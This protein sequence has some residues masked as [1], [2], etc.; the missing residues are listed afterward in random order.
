MITK[1]Q[2]DQADLI[3][4]LRKEAD[5]ARACFRTMATQALVFAPAGVAAIFV[6]MRF[7]PAAALA[8]LGIMI[9]VMAIQRVAIHK[10]STSNRNFGYQL[11][12]ERLGA[13]DPFR[14]R[15]IGWEEMCRAWRI[16]QATVFYATY[17]T[18]RAWLFRRYTVW[19]DLWPWYYRLRAAYR[20]PV[21]LSGF[22]S[23]FITLWPQSWR[24]WLRTF[25]SG[26]LARFDQGLIRLREFVIGGGEP[27]PEIRPFTGD[28]VDRTRWWMQ[29]D[30][31]TALRWTANCEPASY[32]AGSYLSR[33]F[34]IL[35]KLQWLCWAPI[36]VVLW[37]GHAPD[38]RLIED[39]GNSSTAQHEAHNAIRAG[40]RDQG[41]LAA[42]PSRRL[43]N[44]LLI[45][46]CVSLV[47]YGL[48]HHS[49][50]RRREI[51]ENEM[52]SIHS[53]AI[54]WKAVAM[55]HQRAWCGNRIQYSERLARIACWYA[56][57]PR[58]IRA[59]IDLPVIPA[60]WAIQP[61]NDAEIAR[62]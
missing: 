53:C 45:S 30:R 47:I 27:P 9:S 18:P 1:R 28:V 48:H 57:E 60:E 17:Q 56:R 11:H 13:H 33:M 21:G 49:V 16:V 24:A 20:T 43:W 62:L 38:I 46:L 29:G 58:K 40:E 4:R 12:L 59:M 39:I 10:F 8:S 52:L 44:L 15:D 50:G 19:A 32:H 34:G 51:L 36:L 7:E 25:A 54:M 22:V 26:F 61:P 37:M 14:L 35:E 23:S 31:V 55:A 2:T 42:V 41:D 5:D 3:D 6:A